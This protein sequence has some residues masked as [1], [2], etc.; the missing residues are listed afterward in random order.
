MD[1]K[2]N[3]S[4]NC[5][6]SPSA[7]PRTEARDPVCGMV[8][9]PAEAPSATIGGTTYYFCNVECREAF[10]AEPHRYLAAGS[11]GAAAVGRSRC[12]G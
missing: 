10:K 8:V 7:S 4:C 1:T 3:S 9:D 6:H 12:C 2:T 5:C 11:R